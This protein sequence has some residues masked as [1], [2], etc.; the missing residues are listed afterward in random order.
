MSLSRLTSA[1]AFG[2]YPPF[3]TRSPNRN[4]SDTQIS[5]VKKWSG[6]QNGFWDAWPAER[7]SIAYRGFV[8]EDFPLTPN[9][10]PAE[11]EGNKT[12]NQPE[13]EGNKAN[14]Q[15]AEG[16]GKKSCCLL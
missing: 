3:F 2:G 6:V 4:V 14:K 7:S 12:K 5:N 9:P 11:G 13:R 10:S 16:E 1:T 15:L 8:W